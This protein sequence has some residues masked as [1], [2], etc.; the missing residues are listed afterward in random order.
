MIGALY[1]VPRSPMAGG[2]A[3][4]PGL[5]TFKQLSQTCLAVVEAGALPGVVEGER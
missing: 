4:S 3:R 2:A 5:A 1:P